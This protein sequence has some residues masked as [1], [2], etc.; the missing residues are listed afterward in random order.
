MEKIGNYILQEQ[1]RET[2]KAVIFRAHTHGEAPKYII[3]IL[4][5]KDP[6]P[7]ESARFRQE[8]NLI[9]N[10]DIDGIVRIYDVIEQD[11]HF[12]I[13]EE[14]F[15]GVSLKELIKTEKIDLKSFLQ[16]AER[17]SEIL[18]GIH[19][20]NI[21][22][23]DIKPDNI[24]INE[25][26]GQIK[27]ADFG[28]AAILTHAN[29]ELYHPEVIDDTLVYISP[30]QTGR[31]N[32][33]IDYRTDLYS[34]GITFYEMLTGD[35]PFRSNDPMELIHA[36]IARKPSP[37]H[38]STFPIPSIITEIIAKLLSKNPEER[39]QN[40][41][42]VMADIQECIRQVDEKQNIESFELGKHDISNR[43][44]IPQKLFGREKDIGRL[45]SSFDTV[46]TR[47]NG[48]AIMVVM[49]A[50][51]IGKSAMIN[52]IYKPIV[53]RKGYFISG[54]YEQ[55]RR[56]KPYSGIIQAFQLFVK[57]ILSESEERI[58]L[59]K[60]SLFNVL[61]DSGKVITDV[62]PEV[63]LII[64]KQ[65]DLPVLGPE[66]SKNRFNFIFEKFTGVFPA[67]EHP[68]ALF[69]DDLQW[70][71][72]ASLQLLQN[73]LT[74]SGLNYFFLIL[75]YRDNEVN[76][77]HPVM[78]FLRHIE[79]N[80]ARLDKITLGALTTRDVTDFI[81]YFLR[82]SD[83]EGMELAELLVKKTGGN[84]FFVNQFLHT[85]YNEKMIVHE[86][87]LG[88]RWDV[89]KIS[90]MQVTDNLVDMMAGKISRLPEATQTVL[91]ICA[92]I[93]NRF[94]LETLAAV[95]GTS[96]DQALGDLTEAVNEGLVSR[97]WNMYIFHHDR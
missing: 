26:A 64:G 36:H 52:E 21:V 2:R 80:K 41:F 70:A 85:L 90:Q 63:E 72:S 92:C 34:L 59:W 25:Q 20:S 18:G 88:W 76:E 28:I 74:G 94:D 62:I 13:V 12:V 69:L 83:Q 11:N 57:Q 29:E 54:K 7:S 23:L 97:F 81:K 55:F 47:K 66:E 30:E 51:G 95:Q 1:I 37:S 24:L 84:P 89:N 77:S 32:R 61:G 9:K 68:V 27:I 15:D 10:L 14:D 49:G 53:A 16:I 73:I 65:S 40:G 50:P 79:K 78:D 60:E 82:C 31:M 56:D 3:K 4:K 33:T 38:N 96:V 93:G 91:K 48:A 46:A 86:G 8:C 71:D 17:V 22:H 58:A 19:K 6:T 42:G 67:K 35:V 75:S 45:I 5:T 44:I 87:A 39:Y 43:F